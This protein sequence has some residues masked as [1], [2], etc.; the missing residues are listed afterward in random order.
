MSYITYKN[1]FMKW[2]YKND[3]SLKKEMCRVKNKVS[4]TQVYCQFYGQTSIL[5]ILACDSCGCYCE[6]A[7]PLGQMQVLSQK[8]TVSLLFDHVT[9]GWSLIQRLMLSYDCK[10]TALMLL[11]WCDIFR[12]ESLIVGF[13]A[14]VLLLISFRDF[15]DFMLCYCGTYRKRKLEVYKNRS[16]KLVL[17]Y[18]KKKCRQK[19]LEIRKM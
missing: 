16:V 3:K 13:R 9:H 1:M 12:T 10:W 11:K 18:R 6:F 5:S 17:H 2:K 4:L 19:T 8:I 14:V 15:W 7:A